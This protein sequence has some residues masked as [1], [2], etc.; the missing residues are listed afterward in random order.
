[1]KQ[2]TGEEIVYVPHYT[3]EFEA[4]WIK[5]GGPQRGKL[6]AVSDVIVLTEDEL[7]DLLQEAIEHS[8]P[9]LTREAAGEFLYS[10]L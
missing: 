6:K 9:V 5:S 10:K 4:C 8:H 7:L 3:G 2:Y 1:M